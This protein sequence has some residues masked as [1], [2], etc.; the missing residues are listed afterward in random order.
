MFL[1]CCTKL[2]LE[3]FFLKLSSYQFSP[4]SER[5]I[6]VVVTSGGDETT[7]QR[8]G[9][10]GGNQTDL[11]RG[12][13]AEK[14]TESETPSPPNKLRDSSTMNGAGKIVS[15]AKK[16]KTRISDGL[17][18]GPTKTRPLLS[19]RRSPTSDCRGL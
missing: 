13:V 4:R 12:T 1:L 17:T 11:G 14:D 3:L 19:T 8:R 15:G 6:G 2:F 18:A 7:S 5:S 16:P 10:A 9:G